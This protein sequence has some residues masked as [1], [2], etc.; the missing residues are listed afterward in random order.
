[1]VLRKSSRCQACTR[2]GQPNLLLAL[3]LGLPPRYYAKRCFLSLIE[4]LAK[5][6]IILKDSS[7][8]EIMAFLHEAEKHGKDIRVS[9]SDGKHQSRTIASE[10]RM[11][12]KMFLKLRD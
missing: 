3:A 7:F 2:P 12:K 4:N 1:M 11:L 5:H 10:A 8:T 6:M 9:F